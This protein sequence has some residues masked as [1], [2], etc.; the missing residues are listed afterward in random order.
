MARTYEL[1]SY[2]EDALGEMKIDYLTCRSD[3]SARSAAGRMAKKIGGPVDLAD[4]GSQP[5]DQRY[6]TT[7]S[8]SEYHSSGYRCERLDS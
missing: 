6:M 5:W 1:R 3:S 8:P 7:A 2:G 4:V